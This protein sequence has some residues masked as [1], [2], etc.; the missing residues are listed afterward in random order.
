VGIVNVDLVEA[1]R[2]WRASTVV[3]VD[4][5][6]PQLPRRYLPTEYGSNLLSEYAVALPGCPHPTDDAGKAIPVYSYGPSLR[7]TLHSPLARTPHLQR[8]LRVTR[9]VV[10]V[11][12]AQELRTALTTV[13]DSTFSMQAIVDALVTA[14]N[15]NSGGFKTSIV[16]ISQHSDSADAC[17]QAATT[18]AWSCPAQQPVSRD[19]VQIMT[20]PEVRRTLEDAILRIAVLQC[21]ATTADPLTAL[22][23]ALLHLRHLL[24]VGVAPTAQVLEPGKYP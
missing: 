13:L 1:Y 19:S 21:N 20:S 16:H 3:D 2:C 11:R 22:G 14:V 12:A 5:T 18:L 6:R 17:S 9:S 15:S 10:T 23:T 24:P 7:L 8:L 4:D